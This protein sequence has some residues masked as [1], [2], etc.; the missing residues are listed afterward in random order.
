MILMTRQTAEGMTIAA[1]FARR[2]HAMRHRPIVVVVM[3]EF[4]PRVDAHRVQVAEW[5]TRAENHGYRLRIRLD[6]SNATL[7]NEYG[8]EWWRSLHRVQWLHETHGADRWFDGCV[9]DCED[10]RKL[11]SGTTKWF[12]H[13][14]LDNAHVY[15]AFRR[16]AAYRS[17]VVGGDSRTHPWG[18][19]AI[20][21]LTGKRHWFRW[22]HNRQVTILTEST[23]AGTSGDLAER[24]DR[25]AYLRPT[26]LLGLDC[27]R[28]KFADANAMS[29]AV[30][31]VGERSW[32][33]AVDLEHWERLDAALAEAGR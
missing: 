21:A 22:W 25:L 19:Y 8:A 17:W 15:D 1:K 13:T 5:I 32:Y 27:G 14:K 33:M 9:I 4:L 7:R 20:E 3:K 16:I 26:W 12:D 24:Q 30:A 6:V 2:A 31:Y 28:A 29:D 18:R 11:P 23:F 10:Y